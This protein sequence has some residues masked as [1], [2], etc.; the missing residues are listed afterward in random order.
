MIERAMAATGHI[1]TAGGAKGWRGMAC[2]LMVALLALLPVNAY[3][4][5]LTVKSF[6][7]A[8][9]GGNVMTADIQVEDLNGEL[10]ALVKVMLGMG[11]NSFDRLYTSLPS[12]VVT[13]S[14]R[15]FEPF[16]HNRSFPMSPNRYFSHPHSPLLSPV[17]ALWYTDYISGLGDTD[18]ISRTNCPNGATQY[19]VGFYPMF[20]SQYIGLC[21][22]ATANQ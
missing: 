3:A 19:S 1:V 21:P 6:G 22:I 15:Y 9:I 4:K 17:E 13:C 14:C 12:S 18:W 16:T 8:P 10:C 2:L 20:H 11:Q 5:E 7:E